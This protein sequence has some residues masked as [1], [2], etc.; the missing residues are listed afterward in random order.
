MTREPVLGGGE[1][2]GLSWLAR[3]E[4]EPRLG[5]QQEPQL[6]CWVNIYGSQEPPAP[7]S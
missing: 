5:A 1:G 6:P 7:P 2:W 4:A 3:G